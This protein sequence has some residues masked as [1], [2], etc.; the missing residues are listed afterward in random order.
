[1]TE[2]AVG[3]GSGEVW[4]LTFFLEEGEEVRGARCLGLGLDLGDFSSLSSSLDHKGRDKEK[5]L[6]NSGIVDAICGLLVSKEVG[7]DTLWVAR[8]SG[9]DIIEKD[10][11]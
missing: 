7:I 3:S 2:D 8:K 5:D 1:M 6:E 10:D 11:D 9:I 4:A